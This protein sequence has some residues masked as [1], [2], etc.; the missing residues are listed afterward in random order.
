MLVN[1]VGVYVTEGG[2]IAY[3]TVTDGY[4]RC[5][6]YLKDKPERKLSWYTEDGSVRHGDVCGPGYDNKL[7]VMVR[8]PLPENAHEYG[9]ECQRLARERHI[10]HCQEIVAGWPEWK[11]NSM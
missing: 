11:R 8:T 4:R 5:Y 7:K 9:Q 3:V 6:G 10:R 2:D 1:Q